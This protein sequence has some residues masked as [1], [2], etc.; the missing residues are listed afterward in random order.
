MGRFILRNV[1]LNEFG[2][3]QKHRKTLSGLHFK[4]EESNVI[5]LKMELKSF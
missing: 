2:N 4:R 1:P 3:V 5:V